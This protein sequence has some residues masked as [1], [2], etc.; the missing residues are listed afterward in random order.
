M[1][2]LKES[3]AT[4]TWMLKTL[5][6]RLKDNQQS[7]SD[8]K[9]L[10]LYVIATCHPKMYYRITN[11]P[12]LLYFDCLVGLIDASFNFV[13]HPEIP[14][15]R[16][17]GF[18]DAIP[19]LAESAT[20]KIPNL[21]QTA[22]LAIEKKPFDIYNKNTYMEFHA[23]LCEL[24]K[25]FR[26]SL[27]D[28][29]NLKTDDEVEIHDALTS[30]HI[31]GDFLWTMARSAAIEKHLKNIND[32]LDFD[33]RGVCNRG[34]VQQQDFEEDIEFDML[35]PY[36]MSKGEP[37]QPWQ[38]YR[39]WL[40]LQTIYFDATEILA[41]YVTS[42]AP[43]VNISIRILSPSLP[44][45][46]ML[47]LESLL[48]DQRYFP[49]P[50]KH[51]YQ[52]SGKVLFDFLSNFTA[53]R[54]DSKEMEQEGDDEQ[55][56]GINGSA[57]DGKCC[58]DMKG[59]HKTGMGVG[60][61]TV[62]QLVK[63]LGGSEIICMDLVDSVSDQMKRLKHCLSPEDDEHVENI[64]Q[65]I[66]QLKVAKLTPERQ[67]TLVTQILDMIA[68]LKRRS[69]L[70][71]KLRSQTLRCGGKF[72]GTRHCEACIASLIYLSAL[73]R[74]KQDDPQVEA[75][76]SEFLVGHFFMPCLIIHRILR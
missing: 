52:P 3:L 65:R 39:D 54:S 67:L 61:E 36:I 46:K 12:S 17:D 16:S 40:R 6:R 70:Y 48:L 28:L 43:S 53:D 75:L 33:H 19:F 49:D 11:G 26:G 63:K 32:L 24:L 57:K 41:Q 72:T 64:C 4:H 73:A 59:V 18:L 9:N 15:T 69:L 42:F 31:M 56:R 51:L 74:S 22:Q 60:F 66:S 76:L 50:S 30:V 55:K 10:L 27:S 58:E 23:L 62:T 21:Q 20:T 5:L 37:L 34:E 13:E 2:R 35:K 7:E 8:M 38:S 47:S 14:S 44:D 68:I 29:V 1:Y 25:R 45:D 71:H